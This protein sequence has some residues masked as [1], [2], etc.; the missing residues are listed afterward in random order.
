[1]KALT[2]FK[3][4]LYI[5]L[6]C[7]V[8]FAYLVY[9]S[10]FPPQETNAIQFIGELFT[11]PLLLFVLFSFGYSIINLFRRRESKRYLIILFVNIFILG[12]LVYVTYL[13]FK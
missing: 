13:E 11:L 10:Y 7:L 12:C 4:L 5:S 8:Y 2:L 3:P 6:F 9:V 1:M